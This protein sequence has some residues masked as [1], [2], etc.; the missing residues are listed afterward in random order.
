[1]SAADE[2]R[3]KHRDVILAAEARAEAE[4][5]AA[6]LAAGLP[7]VVCDLCT[8]AHPTSICSHGRR[9]IREI[10]AATP[11]S[12]P[13]DRTRDQYRVNLAELIRLLREVATG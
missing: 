5:R 4:V 10:E 3:A 12:P 2:I 9:F 8:G 13:P 7:S 11:I 6:E 1:M